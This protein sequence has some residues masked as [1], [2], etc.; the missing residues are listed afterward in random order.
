MI[1]FS[2]SFLDQIRRRISVSDVIGRYVKLETRGS[3][4]LGCCPFHKEKTPS[5]YVYDA[6]GHYHCYGC[7]AHGDIFSFLMEKKGLSFPEAVE[8]LAGQAG[9]PLPKNAEE[10]PQDR[11]AREKRELYFEI[12]EKAAKFFES[13]LQSNDGQ[14]ALSYVRDRRVSQD[15]QKMY[16]LGYAPR[17]NRLLKYLSQDQG[18]AFEDLIKLGLI[19]PSKHDD[20]PNSNPYYDNFRDRLMF[21]IWDMKGRVIA[22]G[23]RILGAGE[24]KYLNSPE[25]PLF[26]KSETVYGYHLA[27][28]EKGKDHPFILSE[29]YVDVIAFHQHG[30][31]GAVA[32]LGTSITEAQLR[33]L[34][35][36]DEAPIICL[37]GDKA[38]QKAAIRALEIAL[39]HIRAKQSLRFVSLPDGEDP[40]TM[41]VSGR[42]QDLKDL[43]SNPTSFSD[44]LWAH[45][46]DGSDLS[47][48]EGKTKFRNR[49][50][51]IVGQIQDPSLKKSYE[52]DFADRLKAKFQSLRPQSV[53]NQYGND[54]RF[55]G[56]QSYGSRSSAA[57]NRLGVNAPEIQFKILMAAALNHPQILESVEDPFMQLV[58]ANERLNLLREEIGSYLFSD[59]ALDTEDL[60][61]HLCS[62]GFKNE[63]E[64]VC[65]WSIYAHAK[66][67]QP[68]EDLEAVKENWLRI[69]QFCHG[70]SALERDIDTLKKQLGENPTL[71][72][73]EKL[74]HL[75]TELSRLKS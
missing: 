67:A 61:H 73:F 36:V 38:G 1:S 18:Y 44:Q 35:R 43:L 29:G 40:D 58:S 28:K 74:K 47:T 75:Q 20:G 65:D 27:R 62:N 49:M 41:L 12:M 13:A 19:K 16:R 50:Y 54:S 59:H 66:F 39:P 23:G 55:S 25:T 31:P 14:T 4:T 5:F 26:H 2:P 72:N 42:H 71:E 21:P 57:K 7:K 37:D 6:D 11:A 30:F 3:N 68:N 69:W 32:P 17:G 52:I 70:K 8:D 45:C 53:K 10:T 46:L 48:P 63:V 33:M 51:D 15:M 56:S 64:S 22:F 34:W 9:I 60:K 24:P